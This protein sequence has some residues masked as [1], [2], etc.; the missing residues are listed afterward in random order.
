MKQ[1]QK[2]FEKEPNRTCRNT[3]QLC[4]LQTQQT[5]NRLGK[6]EERSSECKERSKIITQDVA[7]SEKEIGKSR[8]LASERL[9]AR[10]RWFKMS[11]KSRED[12][13]KIG[14]S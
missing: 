4:L 10:T 12:Q 3:V 6:A 7:Q 5:I 9:A 2:I 1:E 14:K 11:N 13:N 8:L